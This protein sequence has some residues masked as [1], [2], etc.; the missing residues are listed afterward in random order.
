[1]E[2]DQNNQMVVLPYRREEMEERMK[3][4][5]IRDVAQ[6][7][8]QLVHLNQAKNRFNVIIVGGGATVLNSAPV[9]G[10]STGGP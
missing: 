8:H 9:R 1:M 10:A 7:Q 2:Q 4:M 3:E 5:D 6:L